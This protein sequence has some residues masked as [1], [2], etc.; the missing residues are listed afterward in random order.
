[1]IVDIRST[2]SYV[3]FATPYS[4]TTVSRD[5]DTTRAALEVGAAFGVEVRMAKRAIRASKRNHRSGSS[6]ATT[7]ALVLLAR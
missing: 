7:A 2:S 3:P 5:A 6:A 4:S 1:M